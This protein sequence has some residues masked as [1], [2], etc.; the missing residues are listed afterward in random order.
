MG[1]EGR[2][3]VLREED[4]SGG[5]QERT[6]KKAKRLI[7]LPASVE[8]T[9][10]EHLCAHFRADSKLCTHGYKYRWVFPAL[11][12]DLHRTNEAVELKMGRNDVFVRC[13]NI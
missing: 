13:E 1:T 10:P 6:K 12:M 7:Y 8:I 4:I 9:L 2:Y 11:K 5:P 3:D